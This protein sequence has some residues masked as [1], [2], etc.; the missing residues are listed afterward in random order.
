MAGTLVRWAVE[1]GAA[2]EQGDTIAVLEAMKM[3]TTVT[4]PVTG[5]VDLADDAPSA[6]DPVSPTTVLARIIPA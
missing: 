2:V 3:E 6:G 4:A 1:D 5:T